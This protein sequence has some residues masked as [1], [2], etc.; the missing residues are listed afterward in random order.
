VP[1]NCRPHC[2]IWPIVTDDPVAW[3][4]CDVPV[5]CKYGSGPIRDGDLWG[6]NAC[7]TGFDAA[8]SK[9]LWTLEQLLFNW[10]NE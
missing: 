6:P 2:I 1:L 4:V 5:L 10:V 3:C 9:L 8:F 7:I